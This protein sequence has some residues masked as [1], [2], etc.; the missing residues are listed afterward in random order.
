[1]SKTVIVRYKTTADRADENEG[2]VRQIFDE[3]TATAPDGVRYTALRLDDGVS[4]IHI[5][6]IEALDGSNPILTLPCACRKSRPPRWETLSSRAWRCSGSGG[7][8]AGSSPAAADDIAV[9]AQDR[10]GGD[11]RVQRVVA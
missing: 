7:A 2:L 6:T 1:M 8:L 3:L 10:A 9:P 11:E 4:F 5:A